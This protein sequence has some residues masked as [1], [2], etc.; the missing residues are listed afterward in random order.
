MQQSQ[1][2]YQ[3]NHVKFRKQ[4]PKHLDDIHILFDKIHVTG[5]SAS[6]PGDISSD[7]SSAEDVS[8]VKKNTGSD[9]VKLATLKKA[10]KSGKMKRKNCSTAT[11][12][13]EE[14]NPFF[15]LYNNTCLKIGT[16]AEKIS[17]RFEATSAPP[18]NPVPSIKETMQMVEDCGVKEKTALMHTATMMIMKSEFREVFSSLKTNEGRL[19]LLER[20]H[21]KELM[22][23]L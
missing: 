3:C 2:K 23:R 13:K 15:R 4:G 16:A 10:T 12:E 9:D 17:T 11:E 1:G 18:T 14:K 19:D 7:E 21:E 8:E 20:E 22:K 5:A 6:Y